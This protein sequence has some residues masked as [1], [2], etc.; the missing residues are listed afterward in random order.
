MVTKVLT[1]QLFQAER[2]SSLFILLVLYIVKVLM[3]RLLI[4]CLG[5]SQDTPCHSRCGF[6]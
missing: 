6:I 4:F 3:I 1:C 5:L 2:M